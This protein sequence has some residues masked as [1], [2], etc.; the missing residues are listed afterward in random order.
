MDTSLW[1]SI[2]QDSIQAGISTSRYH[3]A[4][5]KLLLKPYHPTLI[6]DLNEDDFEKRS[7]SNEMCLEKFNYDPG[8]GNRILW[9][10]ECRF[11]RNETVTRHSCTYWSTENPAEKFSVP[12]TEEGMMCG[13][14]YRQMDSLVFTFS[15]KQS[16]VQRIDKCVVD[17]V[18]SQLQGKKLYFQHDGATSHCAVI[19]CECP[20]EQFRGRWID[21]CGPFD[22]SE[23]SSDLTACDF[24]LW[25]YLKDTVFKEACASIMQ[26]QNRIQEPCAG[27]TKA[28]CRKVCYFVAQ[29]L[30]DCLQKDGQFLSS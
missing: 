25:R 9:S 8:F 26:L 2:R 16:R 20:G 5:Q 24:F 15:M 11:N 6:V 17:Y 23:R 4:M 1:L 14:V 27:I 12:N 22:W 30:R 21:R 19:V 3:A 29:R 7:Q 28:M 10:D 13:V 18:W